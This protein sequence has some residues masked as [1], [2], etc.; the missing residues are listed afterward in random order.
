MA[1]GY[2]HYHD[3]LLIDLDIMPT[4]IQAETVGSSGDQVRSW[5][6]L[7]QASPEDLQG[8]LSSRETVLQKH[9]AKLTST[10]RP[11]FPHPRECIGL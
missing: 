2:Q 7:Y 9:R 3:D 10:H 4:F 11:E 5:K 8:R 1:H 6:I